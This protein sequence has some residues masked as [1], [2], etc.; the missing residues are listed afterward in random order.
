M[1]RLNDVL[2]H[3]C[4][5][6]PSRAAARLLAHRALTLL[7]ASIATLASTNALRGDTAVV[8]WGLNDYGQCNVPAGLAPV[9]AVAAGYFHTVALKGDATVACWGYNLQ[10]QCN[11]PAELAI[12]TAVA[13]GYYH[14]V[15]LKGDGTVA[16]WGRNDFGQ[17]NVPAGLAPVTAVAAGAYHTVVR[18]DTDC[19]SN[20]V[21][22]S[23]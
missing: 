16:C 9:I 20:S 1:N 12:V 4:G 7:A 21:L 19:N 11:V 23:L 6:R 13:A 2:N 5:V 22:D 8:C 15:A 10:G 14:T 3:A 18:L 17:C